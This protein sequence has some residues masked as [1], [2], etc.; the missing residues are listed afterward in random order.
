MSITPGRYRALRALLIAGAAACAPGG[1]SPVDRV[2]P[3]RPPNLVFIMAD[4][5]G[6]GDIEPYGQTR[7][8]TPNLSRMAREGVRFTQ[9]Y[10]AS[11]VC[12]PARSSLMT[13][14]HT[15]HTPIRGN[16]EVLPLGQEPLPAAAITVAE[17]LRQAGYVTGAFG[18]WGLGGPGTEGA[19]TR[20]GFDEFYG[21]LDQRRAHFYYPEF[22]FRGEQRETLPG[23]RVR[24]S[25]QA[26][27]AGWA[28]QRGIYSHDAI[29]REALAFI[30]RNRHRPF[31]LYVPF[32]IPHAELQAP[33]DAYSPYVDAHGESIFPETPYPGQHYGPQA[34]PRATYA[35]MVT[36]MDRDVGRI[37]D[38]LQELGLA[39]KTYV[40]FTSDN[41]P[42]RE[43]G[44][45]PDFFDGNG[46]LRGDKRDLYE[47]GI[48][49]P[50][51]VWAPGRV[52]AGRTSNHV[53]TLWDAL[54]TLAGLAGAPV[55]DH[56]DGLDMTNALTGRAPAP[57]HEFLYW[58]FHEQGGKQA[59]RQGDWK[60]VRLDLTSN[61]R[62]PIELYDLAVDPGEQR[63]VAAQHPRIVRDLEAIMIR[64]HTNSAVFPALNGVGGTDRRR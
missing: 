15:G 35:A 58:E 31:F 57:Q 47:G 36:R 20:Q 9:F 37:I 44:H 23:N 55:P 17:V 62:T 64:E 16:R 32:T 1:S 41:G 26:V 3:T 5:L 18:K 63:D 48:R 30:D 21:Y 19:P 54:P 8:R 28:L 14:Q 13:G 25:E 34:R 59:V 2:A 24:P 38:R 29:A 4:D 39:D 42:H 49:V 43:G 6:Y 40:F 12:A 50:M 33:D 51:L 53:W 10:S 61:P 52:P 22:L 45:D 56:I 7:I 46:P 11:T 60:A 27:G